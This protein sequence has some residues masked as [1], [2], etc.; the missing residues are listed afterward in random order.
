M[1]KNDNREIDPSWASDE[2]NFTSWS[3]REHAPRNDLVRSLAV[4]DVKR[5]LREANPV[6]TLRQSNCNKIRARDF[7]GEQ[8]LTSRGL[9]SRCAETF[10]ASEAN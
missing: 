2:P 9:T 3:D 6:V 7:L 1:R 4:P 8:A 5:G 10:D